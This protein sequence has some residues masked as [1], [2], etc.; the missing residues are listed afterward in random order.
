M[1]IFCP[2]CKGT[3]L[4]LK[5]DTIQGAQDARS[6]VPCTTLP[7]SIYTPLEQRKRLEELHRRYADE[8]LRSK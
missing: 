3:G 1:Y 6:G 7:P 4:M 2:Y 8:K 5:S